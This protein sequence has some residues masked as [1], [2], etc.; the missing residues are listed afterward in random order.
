MFRLILKGFFQLSIGNTILARLSGT[1][2]FF[3]CLMFLFVRFVPMIAMFEMK[4]L[5]PESKAEGG[6]HG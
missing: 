6:S 4:M 5:L 1:I 2:G 3:L